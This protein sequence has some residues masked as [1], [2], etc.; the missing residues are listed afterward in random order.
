MPEWPMLA[1]TLNPGKLG[2][3]VDEPQREGHSRH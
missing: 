3:K 2:G 1:V